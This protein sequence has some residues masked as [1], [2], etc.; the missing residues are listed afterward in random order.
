MRRLDLVLQKR[1]LSQLN[2]ELSVKIHAWLMTHIDKECSD[3][4]HTS[5]D[6]RPFSLFTSVQSENIAVRLSLLHEAAE[7]LL[8]ALQKAYTIDISGIGG[9]LTILERI[10]K[11]SLSAEQL[12]HLSTPDGF[13]IILVSPATY[14]H[15]RQA[16]NLYSLPP[17]LYTAAAK[18][19]LF[20]GID[21]PNE[22]IFEICDRVTY[23]S[24]ILR[25]AIYKI[26][27]GITRPGFE[28]TLSLR[29]GGNEEQRDK[30]ALL[31]RY[32]EPGFLFLQQ[33][34][35]KNFDIRLSCI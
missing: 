21:I 14:R 6:I 33:N 23:T 1:D 16:S 35:Y 28:G 17:L 5:E 18:M 4:L 26:K 3:R 10:L 19:R 31:L 25:T 24:Y 27:L 20:E 34:P 13:N 9:S 7:P 8:D 32:A 30:L 29:P 12:R 15:N 2:C 22:E 11:P